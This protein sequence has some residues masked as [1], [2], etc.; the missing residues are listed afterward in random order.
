MLHAVH[1]RQSTPLQVV[2]AERFVFLL[3]CLSVK[4]NKR[5][6]DIWL[7]GTILNE[8]PVIPRFHAAHHDIDPPWLQRFQS[9][10]FE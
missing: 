3:P 9:V 8:S 7:N 5:S 4:R 1:N 10:G 2:A 6:R